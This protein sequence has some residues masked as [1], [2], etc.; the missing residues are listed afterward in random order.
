MTQ[1]EMKFKN[2]QI[3]D[4]VKQVFRM[5]I[6]MYLASV[7]F[8]SLM[9]IIVRE[10]PDGWQVP[11]IWLTVVLL[12]IVVA[13]CITY[14]ARQAKLLIKYIAKPTEELSV[15]AEQISHGKFDGE[16]SHESDDEIGVL[17]CNFRR[18]T[19]TLH[20]IMGDL[21]GMLEEIAKGNYT[22][23]LGCE[24]AYVGEFKL[25]RNKLEDTVARIRGTLH[26]VKDSS[27]EVAAGARQLAIS[28]QELAKGA[29]EQSD[30]V[31]TLLGNVSDVAVQVAANTTSTDIVH[32][33]VKE[34]G[35]EADISQRKMQELITAM[36]RI[37]ETSQE[38]ENVIVE[39]E[40]IAS[41]TNLLALNAS[42]E[43]ARAGDAGKGFAVVA[44][45][46]RVLSESS[47]NSAEASKTLLKT[48]RGEVMH[49]NEV[50]RET[51]VSLNKVLGHLEQI[52]G[53]VANIRFA[54]DQQTDSVKQIE[55][56]VR[57]ISSVIQTNAAASEETS[58]TSQQLLAEAESL[59][60]LVNQFR[61]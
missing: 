8:A 22:V 16:I 59:D 29:E 5:I 32:D 3:K 56:R 42:I 45:Q 52:I 11:F 2:K 39:I 53:E 1:Q 55:D 26:I 24:E 38:I 27:D 6:F 35:I 41:Q 37:S 54:S 17:A 18:T 10:I 44:D 20:K 49:G 31:E 21:N 4:K 60:G 40:N 30:A 43:A 57:Q 36:A 50:M 28:S 47:A 46:I 61:L 25:L 51:S 48:N 9:L 23:H 12:T 19:S 13:V 33:R 15:V 7:L 14:T 58:A 34:V